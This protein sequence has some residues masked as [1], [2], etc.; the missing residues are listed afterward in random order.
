MYGMSRDKYLED[1]KKSAEEYDEELKDGARDAVKGGFILDQLALQE[2]LTVENEELTEY[3]VRNAMQMGVQPDVL[4]KHLTENGQIPAVVSE[5]LRTKALNLVVEHVKATDDKGNDVDI[6]AMLRHESGE[7][8]EHAE[9]T[10][11]TP[12]APDAAEADEKAD[13][14][15]EEKKADA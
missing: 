10:D 14:K 7:D 15:A 6:A 13:E 2:E 3:V 5:V 1:E 4:A 12:E 9:T 8:G 11:E